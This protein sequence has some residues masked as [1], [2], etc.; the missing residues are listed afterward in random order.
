LPGVSAAKAFLSP[1]WFHLRRRLRVPFRKNS[2]NFRLFSGILRYFFQK[3][4]NISANI[5]LIITEIIFVAV[6]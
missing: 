2:G 3:A 6:I 5:P 1:L 4:E